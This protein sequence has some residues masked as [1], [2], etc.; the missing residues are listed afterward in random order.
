MDKVAD[1]EYDLLLVP[2]SL[3]IT[4]LYVSSMRLTSYSTFINHFLFLPWV[5]DDTLGNRVLVQKSRKFKG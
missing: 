5:H 3:L 1:F 4:V 2:N